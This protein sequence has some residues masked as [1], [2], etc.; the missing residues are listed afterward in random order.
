MLFNLKNGM[1]PADVRQQIQLEKFTDRTDTICNESLC[2]KSEL[3]HSLKL[4]SLGSIVESSVKSH[5]TPS[6]SAYKNVLKSIN[7]TTKTLDHQASAKTIPDNVKR[8][9][10]YFS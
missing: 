3:D 1:D 7:T 5:N 8:D 9:T 10:Q 2:S 6:A 4:Q